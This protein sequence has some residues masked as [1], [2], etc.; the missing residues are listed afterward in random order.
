MNFRFGQNRKDTNLKD[1]SLDFKLMFVYHISMM[2]LFASTFIR[3]PIHQ[4]Y[5]AAVLA[6]VLV[7][8]SIT[9]KYKSNWSW[10]GFKLS[11][12][13]SALFNLVFIYVFLVFS[14]NLLGFSAH[15]FP[16]N[17]ES[18]KVILAEAPDAILLAASNPKLTPWYLGAFGI[19]IMNIL[20]SLRLATLK[21]DD[22][23][24]QCEGS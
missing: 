24:A 18:V 12:L 16:Q 21:K 9:H 4:V 17:I 8:I 23:E 10:P 2:V 22:F 11:G 3:N 6:T 14:A 19:G 1:M 5:F 20:I 13:L 7:A 15:G